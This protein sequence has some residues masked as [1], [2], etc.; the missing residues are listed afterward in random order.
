MGDNSRPMPLFGSLNS[1]GHENGEVPF[2][3]KD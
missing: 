1:A 2:V 3:K